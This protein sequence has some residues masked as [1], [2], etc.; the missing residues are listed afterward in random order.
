M[1]G[2][3][4][5]KTT[6]EILTGR[7]VRSARWISSA[8]TTPT[9]A[10]ERGREV[11]VIAVGA[12]AIHGSYGSAVC[13]SL[14]SLTQRRKILL[15]H[16]GHR[17]AEVHRGL[18]LAGWV[19]RHEPGFWEGPPGDSVRR[20]WHRLHLWLRRLKQRDHRELPGSEASQAAVPK[21]GSSGLVVME[22]EPVDEILCASLC[23]CALCGSKRSSAVGFHCP[24][25]QCPFCTIHPRVTT[26]VRAFSA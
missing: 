10:R 4:K 7:R 23:L 3:R 12:K 8:R 6:R 11:V 16:G 9:S 26:F 20:H 24:G 13:A 15:N 1:K 19:S 2:E 5:T 17:G 18:I 25:P 21:K 14:S 22:R